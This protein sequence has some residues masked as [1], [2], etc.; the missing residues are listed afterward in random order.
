MIR[1]SGFWHEAL[2]GFGLM[3]LM[4]ATRFHH[5]GNVTTLPDASLAVFFLAGLLLASPWIFV[6][7]LIEAAL[8]DYLAIQYGGVS[9][10]CVTPAYLFLVPTYGVMW[11]GGRLSQAS[12]LDQWQGWAVTSGTLLA[13]T[14]N[15]FL[16]SNFSFYY[17]SGYFGQ[18]S[19]LEYSQQTL[20]YA[21]PYLTWT[22]IYVFA[23]LVPRQLWRTVS[24]HFHPIT[25]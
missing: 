1:L 16:I 10:W 17:L 3:G 14:V 5:F 22:L 2:P 7:L 4:A 18:I 15:A 24:T 21:V 12:P 13:A 11:L 9:D 25:H 6:L 20:P 8:I 19:V 23:V